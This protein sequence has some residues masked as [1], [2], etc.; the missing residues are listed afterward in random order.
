MKKVILFSLLFLFFDTILIAQVTQQTLKYRSDPYGNK[1]FRKKGVM[2]G[3]QIRTLFRNDGQI[4]SWPDRP[5]GE[6]PAGTGHHYMD[7]C[8]PIVSTRLETAVGVVHPALTSYREEVDVDP[9]TG[10]LWVMEP[11]PGYMNASSEEPAISTKP[12]TWPDMW[13][14]ALP[15]I[16]PEWDGYWFG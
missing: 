14:R 2:N 15:L 10:Q 3:N 16:T 8:T 13:P 6:W 9:A 1:T 7:G 4:G 5:S 12:Y 11:V